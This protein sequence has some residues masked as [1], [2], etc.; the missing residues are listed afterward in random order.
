MSTIKYSEVGF[1]EVHYP[2]F[3]QPHVSLCGES[4]VPSPKYP[5]I[6]PDYETPSVMKNR[7]SAMIR[8]EVSEKFSVIDGKVSYIEAGFLRSQGH[9]LPDHIEDEQWLSVQVYIDVNGHLIFDVK[10]PEH[11]LTLVDVDFFPSNV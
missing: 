7:E 3:H 2:P 10:I 5:V 4:H 11:T 9:Q 1:P 8:D 6:L